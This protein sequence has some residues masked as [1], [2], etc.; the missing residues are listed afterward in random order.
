MHRADPRPKMLLAAAPAVGCCR[1]NA[2]PATRDQHGSERRAESRFGGPGVRPLAH[3]GN[4]V[5]IARSEFLPIL[6]FEIKL[7]F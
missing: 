1:H 3:V 4:Y 7:P 6:E 2:G 5:V